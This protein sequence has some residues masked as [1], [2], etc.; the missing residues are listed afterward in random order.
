[1]AGPSPFLPL[2]NSSHSVSSSCS[3]SSSN[4]LDAEVT[5]GRTREELGGPHSG[6][7]NE[8]HDTTPEDN[9]H[10]Y[11]ARDSGADDW[12]RAWDQEDDGFEEQRHAFRNAAP[13]QDSEN[14]SSWSGTPSIK[15]STETVR[16]ML[17]TLNSIGITFVTRCPSALLLLATKSN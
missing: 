2:P 16:M 5:K 15:G 7:L 14:M 12:D 1:M 6:H 9:N 13:T 3:S 11:I 17:L 4:N 10:N 8:A